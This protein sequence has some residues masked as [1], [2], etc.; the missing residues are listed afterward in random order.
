MQ[1]RTIKS[2]T[3]CPQTYFSG[4]AEHNRQRY[5]L[6]S[7]KEKR[8]MPSRERSLSSIS[9]LKDIN[10]NHKIVEEYFSYQTKVGFSS[11]YI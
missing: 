4:I 10:E 1:H 7:T 6:N 8:K 3:N 11:K 9:F 2:K 5:N